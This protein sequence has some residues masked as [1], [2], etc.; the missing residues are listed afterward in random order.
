MRSSYTV[1][2]FSKPPQRE[3]APSGYVVSIALHV[4]IFAVILASVHKVRVVEKEF[5]N[6]KGAV[7]LLNMRVSDASARWYP[8]TNMLRHSAAA[9][10]H[11]A[12]A[13]GSTGQSKIPQAPRISANFATKRPAP[14][15]LIQPEVPPDQQLLPKIPMPQ[16]LVWTSGEIKK[17]KIVTPK[18]QPAGEVHV[19]PSLARPNTELNPA[20]VSLST[21]PFETKAPMPVPGRTTPV[22]VNGPTPAKQIPQT[23]SI[24][25]EQ[26]SPA[27]VI[28]LSDQK[29]VD[30]TAALA[31]VNQVAQADS[32]GSPTLGQAANGTQTGIDKTGSGEA[33]A[34]A[35]RGPGDA[36]NG[37]DRGVAKN[38][39]TGAG[40]AEGSSIAGTDN[41]PSEAM[42]DEHIKLPP[43]GKFGMVVVGA[44]PEE[45]YPETAGLWTGRMVYTVY[46]QTDTS[47][48]WILQYSLLRSLQQKS[49]EKRRPD[50]PYPF[51]MMRPNLISQDVVLVHGFVNESGRFEKLSIA[52]PPAYA[53][54]ALL[55][56]ALKQWE[57]RPA[58][59]EGQPTMVE[60][61]LIIPGEAD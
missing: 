39:G 37:V 35:G 8:P 59:N 19:K 46:L 49:E 6:R 48:N 36:G 29:L 30:G 52:Y 56:R 27:R 22:K 2:L 44:E 16:A 10:R 33:G 43:T 21:I 50:A 24:E 15:T 40:S 34:G 47:Q 13:S 45:D 12:S 57:F 9:A 53:Q 58:M 17:Q 11:A 20:E 61:L 42:G 23:A 54:S 1:T 18:P 60:V 51:D 3:S 28:S 26:V 5:V 14:Q 38:G 41:I 4:F 55:L 32:E 7:R 25:T 31:V